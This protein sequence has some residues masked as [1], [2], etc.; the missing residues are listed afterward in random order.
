MKRSHGSAPTAATNSLQARQPMP[1]PLPG[2]TGC[3]FHGC[4]S[5]PHHFHSGAV[6]GKRRGGSGWPPSANIDVALKLWWIRLF[7]R[8]FIGS[9][10]SDA[11]TAATRLR[12]LNRARSEERRV[13]KEGRSRWSPYH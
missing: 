8:R 1:A 11:G 4:Y 5:I 2:W 13:G 7:Q 10:I 9:E 6:R 12:K 3:Q